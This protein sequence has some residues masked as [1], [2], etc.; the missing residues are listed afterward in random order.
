M[1]VNVYAIVPASLRS[2]PFKRMLLADA[3]GHGLEHP[4]D[5]VMHGLLHNDPQ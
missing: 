1:Q 2:W 4:N 5:H 3:F